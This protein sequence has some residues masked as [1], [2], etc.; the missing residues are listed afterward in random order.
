MDLELENGRIQSGSWRHETKELSSI[1]YRRRRPNNLSLTIR[2]EFKNYF[3]N[4]GKLAW[5]DEMI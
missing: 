3:N 4:E 5:Q 1:N 2:E